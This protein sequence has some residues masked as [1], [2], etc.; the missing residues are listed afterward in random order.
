MGMS[1]T[2]CWSSHSA[3]WTS[4]LVSEDNILSLKVSTSKS[5]LK[6]VAVLLNVYP[7]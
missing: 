7:N 4:S 3:Y 6:I 1:K 5:G 2:V